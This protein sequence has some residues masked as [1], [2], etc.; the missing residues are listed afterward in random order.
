M[1]DGVNISQISKQ[2]TN[3]RYDSGCETG[4]WHINI[5]ILVVW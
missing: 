4:T 5:S 3:S 2:V 1:L